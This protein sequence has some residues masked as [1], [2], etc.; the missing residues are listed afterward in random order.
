MNLPQ[1]PHTEYVTNNA[2]YKLGYIHC[3]FSKPRYTL[4]LL[5][6]ETLLR[7]KLEYASSVRDPCH[8]N[9]IHLFVQNNSIRLKPSHCNCIAGITSM[10]SSRSLASF[11]PPW[12]ISYLASFHELF[13]HTTPHD[14]LILNPQYIFHCSDLVIRLASHYATPSVFIL[15]I[16]TL[17]PTTWRHVTISNCFP[18]NFTQYS[19]IIQNR[20][21][22]ILYLQA[23]LCIV[24]VVLTQLTLC[25][26]EFILCLVTFHA[27]FSLSTL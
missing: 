17:K 11:A 14:Q 6:Y 5:L 15:Y 23:E 26:D 25:N 3:T 13:C 16:G 27:A 21:T 12:K 9:L 24:F 10:K 4:K 8:D 20:L 2:D 22:N 1:A 19:V 7:P 18:I